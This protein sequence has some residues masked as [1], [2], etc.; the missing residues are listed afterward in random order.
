MVVNP[1]SAAGSRPVRSEPRR[2][3]AAAAPA[4]RPSP[5]P[6]RSPRT[7]PSASTSTRPGTGRRRCSRSLERRS[8]RRS[9]PLTK[10]GRPAQARP[11][12]RRRAAHAAPQPMT[13]AAAERHH[14][15]ARAEAA[16]GL[17]ETPGAGENVAVRPPAGAARAAERHHLAGLADGPG[18]TSSRASIR[19]QRSS[20]S[21]AARRRWPARSRR[22]ARC[23]TA[24]WRSRRQGRRLR[25]RGR[26]SSRPTSSCGRSCATARRS[27][28]PASASRSVSAP[29]SALDLK[30]ACS[31][32][33]AP[34]ELQIRESTLDTYTRQ[35]PDQF[36]S[37]TEPAICTCELRNWD[38]SVQATRIEERRGAGLFGRP[39]TASSTTCAIIGASSQPLRLA[40]TARITSPAGRAHH[41][42]PVRRRGAHAG[43]RR[44][45]VADRPSQSCGVAQQLLDHGRIDVPVS[46]ADLH[47]R[48]EDLPFSR[49]A[50]VDAR[51]RTAGTRRNPRARAGCG[52]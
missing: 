35:R 29:A 33:R 32:D 38:T 17:G 18:A 2:W 49:A 42:Q 50:D 44:P 47:G 48:A 4:W 45:R 23:G 28:A 3:I 8:S 51:A 12:R 20:R 27:T 5:S 25:R 43:R 31:L 11:A 46:D 36:R 26:R 19:P 21:L 34:S 15:A 52:P 9:S 6:S 16:G 7:S 41:R 1:A 22:A 39:S 37:S 24:R 30:F 14:P 40:P 13:G 10:A